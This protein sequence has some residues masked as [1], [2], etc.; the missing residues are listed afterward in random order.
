VR[1][2]LDTNIVVAGLLS[3][4]GPPGLLLRA[5][6]QGRFELVTSREQLHELA[7]VLSY[8]HLRD[9]IDPL[10][11]Q[12]F[13]ENVEVLAVVATNLP[14]ID[15]SPDP[16]DNVILASA[17]AGEADLIVS[18]DKVGILGLRVILDIPIVTAREAI[19]RIEG[20]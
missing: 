9:R 10:Q 6:L 19:D 3:A 4:K 7:R 5:W 2:L 20:R 14:R 15:L 1:I 13:V 16:D 18:G 12:D 11:A 17:V 8:P